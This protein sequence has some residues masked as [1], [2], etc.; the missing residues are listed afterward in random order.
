M[1]PPSPAHGEGVQ[2]S[3]FIGALL[4]HGASLPAGMPRPTRGISARLICFNRFI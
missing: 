4:G 3:P 1:S 2:M